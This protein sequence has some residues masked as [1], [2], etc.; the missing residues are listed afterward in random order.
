MDPID[1]DAAIKELR[2][3]A[4]SAEI[5]PFT[6]AKEYAIL[7]LQD[8]QKRLLK[9]PSPQPEAIHINLNDPIKVKL[10]DWGKEIYYHQ[11]DQTNKFVG[12]E[13]CKPS[14]PK[15]DE[16]GYTEFQLWC[17]IELYGPYIG[18]TLPNVIQPLDLIIEPERKTGSVD[19]HHRGLETTD[20]SF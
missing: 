12:K 2:A 3:L 15:E 10:T 5:I 7:I 16:N 4:D 19:R 6:K 20:G 9:L 13:I 11:Y 1:R 18:I 8:A 17:F 14:F